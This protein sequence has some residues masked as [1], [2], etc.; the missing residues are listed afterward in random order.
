MHVPIH[1]VYL[2]DQRYHDR[3]RHELVNLRHRL[4]R[5]LMIDIRLV[6]QRIS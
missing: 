5:Q 4:Y 3:V 6:E 2:I 1:L